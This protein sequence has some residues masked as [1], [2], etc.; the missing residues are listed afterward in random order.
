MT[1]SATFFILKF[2]NTLS[3]ELV[4]NVLTLNKSKLHICNA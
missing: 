4:I 1:N 2:V 3:E